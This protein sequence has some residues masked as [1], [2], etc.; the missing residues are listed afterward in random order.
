MIHIFTVFISNLV[1]MV[2]SRM[3]LSH[4]RFRIV[5][6]ESFLPVAAWLTLGF[7]ATLALYFLYQHAVK[8][9]L[10]GIIQFLI[11]LLN[12]SVY[13]TIGVTTSCIIGCCYL[14]AMEGMFFA[15]E[16]FQFG[17]IVIEKYRWSEDQLVQDAKRFLSKKFHN[18]NYA[19]ELGI[20][21]RDLAQRADF[22]LET[23]RKLLGEEIEKARGENSTWNMWFLSNLQKVVG[24][25]VGTNKSWAI[26]AV[27]VVGLVGHSAL[28]N[29]RLY[30]L[31]NAVF[32]MWNIFQH[33]RVVSEV[34]AA[35]TDNLQTVN[36]CTH[37]ELALVNE[38]LSNLQ[39]RVNNLVEHVQQDVDPTLRT[40]VNEST[41]SMG[42]LDRLVYVVTIFNDPEASNTHIMKAEDT[43]DEISAALHELRPS[44]S[45]GTE[46][47]GLDSRN[48][49]FQPFAGENY[50][51]G[52]A[53]TIPKP[54]G[55]DESSPTPGQAVRAV[56]LGHSRLIPR[57][58]EVTLSEEK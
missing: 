4:Y 41:F 20:D 49:T 1:L 6:G 3:V 35:Q 7:V 40:L 23:F 13:I 45:E 22:D 57:T 25:G 16:V 15:K 2:L 11:R 32:E 54:S 21:V 28:S 18:A 19:E 17:N 8:E 56:N 47:G 24:L 46:G 27:A 42:A 5:S 31:K 48:S 9:G 39:A 43:L 51:L 12:L 29:A 50:V 37:G 30:V 14:I 26:L 53:S 38:Q 55:A 52:D 44:N 33:E 58:L 34:L 10:P 36:A